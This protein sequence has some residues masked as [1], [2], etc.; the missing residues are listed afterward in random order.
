MDKNSSLQEEC[1]E[2][3]NPDGLLLRGI[4]HCADPE[5]AQGISLVCLNT[6]LNDMVGWHR[7]QVKTARFLAENGYNVLRYDDTGIGDSEGEFEQSSVVHIF[8]EIETGLFV[9]N[10]DAAV[11]FMATRFQKDPLIYLG[12]C[13]GGLT[14][15]HS[16]AKNTTINGVVCIGGPV[17]LSSNDYLHKRDPWAVQKNISGYKNKIFNV[18]SWINFLTFRAE[19]KVIVSSFVHYFKHKISGEY[20]EKTD[21]AAVEDAASLNKTIFTSFEVF[22]KRSCPCLFFYADNDSATWEFKKYFL[23]KFEDKYFVNNHTNRFIEAENANHILSSRESQQL[24]KVA[25]LE[26][27]KDNFSA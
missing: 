26:W 3:H 23:A 17:T 6:G 25:V 10:A 14:A 4:L 11:E 21:N 1:V 8:S 2:F 15:I 19:Y 16:A 13:G 5:N 24:L 9:K 22:A 12:F 27:I 20:N 7:I 18:R